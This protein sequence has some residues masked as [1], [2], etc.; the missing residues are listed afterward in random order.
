M[1]DP[2]F[3][4]VKAT[5]AASVGLTSAYTPVLKP[6]PVVKNLVVAGVVA[7]AI[8]SGGLASGTGIAAT[9]SPSL[10]TFFTIGEHCIVQCYLGGGA[11]G[12]C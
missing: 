12:G 1:R 6:I 4:V 5:I 9:L 10:L 2:F 3:L 11:G 7:A 8:A